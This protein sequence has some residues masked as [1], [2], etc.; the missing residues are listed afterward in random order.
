M[1]GNKDNI[2]DN[3]PGTERD[4]EPVGYA[5]WVSQDQA[6]LLCFRCVTDNVEPHCDLLLES[7][8]DWPCCTICGDRLDTPD[9][10]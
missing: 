10:C 9:N 3:Y 1:L 8:D 7:E 2:A 5:F 6:I 4:P